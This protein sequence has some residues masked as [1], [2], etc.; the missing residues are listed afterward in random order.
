MASEPKRPIEE[1]LE[2]SA[3]GR[4]EAFGGDPKMSN[5]MRARL[6]DEIARMQRDEKNVSTSWLQMFWPRLAIAAAV[7]T[8]VVIG[9]MMWWRGSNRGS[10][11]VAEQRS[12]ETTAMPEAAA[13]VEETFAKGPAAAAPP[14]P[15]VNL[16]DNDRETLQ[17]QQT[18]GA[19]VDVDSAKSSQLFADTATAGS[20]AAVTKGL[21][22]KEANEAEPPAA[23]MALAAP[24]AARAKARTD[25]SRPAGAGAA[26][27][28]QK[29]QTGAI[30]AA[31]IATVGPTY[32]FTQQPVGQS[33]QNMVPRRHEA[34]ILNTFEVQQ[35]GTEIRVVD[36][37][38][39]TYTGRLESSE[40]SK[41]PAKRSYAARP[42]DGKTETVATRFRAT[43]FNVSLR[44]SVVF[45]GNYSQTPRQ[46]K[47]PNDAAKNEA[48]T[49]EAARIVGTA[50]VPGQ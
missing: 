10:M 7:A 49:D 17:P 21:I 45:E 36:S 13:P 29:D 24:A 18:P 23:N 47:G 6:H 22:M 34:N 50:R 27:T 8:L 33:F 2:A 41:R 32:R 31:P 43:G 5:P 15:E 37:D 48:K 11:Q 44:K 4:R 20:P 35:Q 30:A 28:A 40:T 19:S 14:A 1:M 3:K 9:P 46:A 42:E 16:A 12:G 39:S 38:G 26:S 25:Q